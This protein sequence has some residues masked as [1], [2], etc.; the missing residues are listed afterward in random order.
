MNPKAWR[1][2]VVP[3]GLIIAAQAALQGTASDALAPPTAALQA[4]WAAAVDGSLWQLTG[5]TLGAAAAGLLL[6]G[7]VG[8]LLGVWFG[9]SRRASQA[10]AP[11][12]E[13]LRPVP[14]VALIPVALLV[15][16]FGWRLEIAVVAFACCFPMLLL[17]RSAVQAVEPRLLEVA[18]VLGL[19]PWR[20]TWRIVLP[21]AVP[22]LF[23]AL[24][25]CAGIAL[26]VAVTTE[27]AANPQGLGFA[28]VSAQQSLMPERMIGLLLWLAL[29]G[30]GLNAG[31]LLLQRRWF[32]AH[33]PMTEA[34][35]AA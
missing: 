20:R 8:V 12:V 31:L 9:L 23:V 35:S 27:V 2:A 1:G 32:G 18:Q 4:L 26:V 14:S 34:G 10:G 29:L 15:F 16:G 19:G 33:S 13:L 30:W 6:G 21:A 28:M 7:G 3:V 11:T 24:R 25:L 5:Q 22:R 17:T